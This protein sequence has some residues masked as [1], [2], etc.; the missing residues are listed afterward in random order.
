MVGL[1]HHR[2]VAGDD[3][4]LAEVG[5]KTVPHHHVIRAAITAAKTRKQEFG[6]ALRL[7]RH[8]VVAPEVV[9]GRRAGGSLLV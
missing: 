3:G 5:P 2:A 8:A 7:E 6:V 9:Q 1:G 4:W